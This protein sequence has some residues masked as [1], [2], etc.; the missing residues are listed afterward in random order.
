MTVFES[1][2][3]LIRKLVKRRQQVLAI[4][5]EKRNKE[6]YGMGIPFRQ[7]FADIDDSIDF[8]LLGS[9]V[10]VNVGNDAFIKGRD[11]AENAYLHANLTTD[12]EVKV[13][14]RL[15]LL[16]RLEEERYIVW[17]LSEDKYHEPGNR[18]F[19]LINERDK[20][21][22]HERVKCEAVATKELAQ[23]VKHG[24]RDEDGVR[25][26]QIMT[27]TWASVF[28]ALFVGLWPAI[29]HCLRALWQ[30]LL[31]MFCG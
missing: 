28:A 4:P 18:L 14:Q 26:C 3:E 24:F 10:F 8:S 9:D 17:S 25:H 30:Y 23:Y 15:L 31:R 27:V 13:L 5:I 12:I 21:F 19:H 7:L 16:Q 11:T 22:T 2:K 6:N 1:D 29:S 20:K